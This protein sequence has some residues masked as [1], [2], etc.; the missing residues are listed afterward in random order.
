[1]VKV[2]C[3]YSYKAVESGTLEDVAF[4]R[5]YSMCKFSIL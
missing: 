4:G 5:L 2:I 3:S 1:M